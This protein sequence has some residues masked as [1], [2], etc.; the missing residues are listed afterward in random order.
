MHFHG[1]S[2]VAELYHIKRLRIPAQSATRL[3]W[4]QPCGIRSIPTP[5]I[6]TLIGIYPYFSRTFVAYLHLQSLN[7]HVPA[8]LK[9]T[10]ERE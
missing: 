5:C 10:I 6:S 7:S 2:R 8:K 1:L 9:I 4:I 3:R